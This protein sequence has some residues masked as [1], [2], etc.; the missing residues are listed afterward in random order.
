MNSRILILTNNIAGLFAFRREVMKALVEAGYSLYI[1][2]PDQDE[3]AGC[4]EEM[5]CTMLFTPFNRKGMNPFADLDLLRRYLRLMKSLKPVAVLTYTIK[6]NIYGGLAAAMCR[7]PQVA[8]VTGLGDALENPGVLKSLTVWLYKTGLKKCRRIFFQ[9]ESNL[10][11][12]IKVGIAT[13]EKSYLLPGSGVNTDFHCYQEYPDEESVKFLF[14]SRL[15]KDKGT[16]EYFDAAVAV[17]KKYPCAEFHIV[18]PKEEAFDAQ[19]SELQANGVVKYFGEQIDV[20]PFI[21]AV[22]CTVMPSYHEGMSNVNLESSANGRPVITT[23]VPGCR[24]TVDDGKTGYLVN[25]KDALDL[26]KKMEKFILLPYEQK[27]HMGLAAREKVEREFRRQIVVDA[28]LNEIS[29]L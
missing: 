9:N 5:G 19:L 21:G 20:R 22:H 11:T 28:Y 8:N 18:G 3:R 24:E 4:F 6:P 2:Y 26:A 27:K 7:V 15:K 1:S 23:D 13:K 14:I 17:K 10:Q 12:C 25:A 29:S 16:Q